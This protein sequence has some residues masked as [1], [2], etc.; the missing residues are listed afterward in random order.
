M[1]NT[2]EEN[3]NTKKVFFCQFYINNT[4]KKANMIRIEYQIY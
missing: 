1:K 3:K 2:S 4:F